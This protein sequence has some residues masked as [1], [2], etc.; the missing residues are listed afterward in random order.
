MR[1]L[2]TSDWHIGLKA[3]QAGPAAPRLRAERLEAGRR[4]AAIAR[5]AQ[6]SFVL[7]AGDL[8]DSSAPAPTEIR[9]TA[10]LL[11]S[12]TIPVYVIPGNHDPHVAGGP[13]THPAWRDAAN[14]R[15]LLTPEPVPLDGGVLYPC[16]LLSRWQGSHPLAWI[17]ARQPQDGIRIG[18][19]HGGL[20]GFGGPVP[21]QAAQDLGLDYL[22]LGDWHSAS[23][24][25]PGC[26]QAYSGTPETDAFGQRD[27]GSVLVID[28]A[29]PGAVPAITRH[30]SGR[31]EW[32]KQS[33]N[34]ERE[35]D[36][37]SLRS[38]LDAAADPAV[39][40]DLEV[41]GALYPGDERELEAI[42]ALLRDRFFHGRL[43]RGRLWPAGAEAAMPPGLL[44]L[45]EARL[46][47][48]AEAGDAIA[49]Q[50]LFELRRFALEAGL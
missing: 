3:A 5:D 13:W 27:S 35:G 31:L 44:T 14:V 49:A 39:L 48:Q 32:R 38:A 23:E 37:A 26:L 10:A 30:R 11:S 34:L 2:H 20:A 17:P 43:T 16:P 15:L 50:A 29:A 22:A 45:A 19:A 1:F 21:D 42:E 12:F 18:L 28:I 33:V 7:L 47:E 41:A 24:T 25:P 8:F 40:L 36:A 6:V 46:R 4:I 9:E